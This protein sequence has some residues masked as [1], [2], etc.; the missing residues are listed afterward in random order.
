MGIVVDYSETWQQVFTE[1]SVALIKQEGFQVIKYCHASDSTALYPELPSWVLDFSRNLHEPF[2][3]IINSR[4][5]PIFRY[6]LGSGELKATFSFS[7]EKMPNP[8]NILISGTKVDVIA[9]LVSGNLAEGEDVVDQNT[10]WLANLELFSMKGGNIY[11]SAVARREAVW[12]TCAADVLFGINGEEFE[13]KRAGA[14][15]GGWCHNFISYARSK[16]M[17]TQKMAR[18]ELG[19]GTMFQTF[20]NTI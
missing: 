6:N 1:L 5:K 11:G 13:L 18:D 7:D 20:L 16:N 8:S 3:D 17:T 4:M 14:D 10:S 19:E 15:A 9:D 2:S 12:R